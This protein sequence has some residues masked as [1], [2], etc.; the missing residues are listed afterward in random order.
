M[1][2]KVREDRKNH[3][4]LCVQLVLN[5]HLKKYNT[6]CDTTSFKYSNQIIL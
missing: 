6:Q 4:N 2:E 1:T 5:L 3:E